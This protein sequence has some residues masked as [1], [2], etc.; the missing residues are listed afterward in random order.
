MKK[1]A[2]GYVSNINPFYSCLQKDRNESATAKKFHWGKNIY[3][4]MILHLLLAMLF[5]TLCRI[6][7]Y[8]FNTAYFP[9]VTFSIFLHLLTGGL[10]FDLPG[11]LYSN[12]LFIL[13]IIVPHPYRYDTTYKKILKWV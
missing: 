1:N 12:I 10:V 11:V 7:Y 4:V 3:I 6:G 5:Y 13:L 9:D 8:L 2:K